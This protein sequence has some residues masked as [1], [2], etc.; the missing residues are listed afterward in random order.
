[1]LL[2]V[3]SMYIEFGH[4]VEKARKKVDDIFKKYDTDKSEQLEKEEFIRFIISDQIA[5]RIFL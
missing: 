1:M 5:S 3:E 2:M 4:D